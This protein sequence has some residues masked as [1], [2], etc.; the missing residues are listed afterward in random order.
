MTTENDLD[1]PQIETYSIPNLGGIL[2]KGDIY[3][4]MKNGSKMDL[5]SFNVF[6]K[7]IKNKVSKKHMN[8]FVILHTTMLS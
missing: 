8:S 2:T 4:K 6:M 1:D 3:K 5:W 7:Y